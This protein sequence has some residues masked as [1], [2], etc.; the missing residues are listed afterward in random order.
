M[1]IAWQRDDARR[2]ALDVVLASQQFQ[3]IQGEFPESI[4]QLVPKFLDS[5][6]IDPMDATGAPLHYRRETD[7]TAVV[8]S[9]GMDGVD[10]GGHVELKDVIDKD[11]GYRI[12]LKPRP[13]AVNR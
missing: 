10:D 8:W 13:E 9:V 2:A 1:D 11:T 6:P 3:R 4:E 7:G 12:R 5:V